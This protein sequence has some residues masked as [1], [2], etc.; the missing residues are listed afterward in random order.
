MSIYNGNI[1]Q[2][3]DI[4]ALSQPQLLN[5]FSALQ[6]AFNKNHVALSDIVNR[7]LHKFVEMPVQSGAQTTAVGEI[8]LHAQTS[9]GRSCLY[10]SRDNDATTLTQLTVGVKPFKST[11]GYSFI[12]GGMII[13]WGQENFSGSTGTIDF[14][15]AF[16]VSALMVV[17]CPFNANAGASSFYISTW[18]STDFTI[19]KSGSSSTSFTYW[20]VGS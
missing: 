10:Y 2:P 16:P 13:Q 15:I 9:N 12:P 18:T 17:A 20:A 7:G 11:S 14:P 5:N 4:P 8:E 1:P 19:K 6:D 3:N